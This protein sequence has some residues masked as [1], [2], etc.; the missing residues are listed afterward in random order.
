MTIDPKLINEPSSNNKRC[1]ETMGEN[2][3]LSQLTKA[4]LERH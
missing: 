4:V 3:T 1:R 2:G